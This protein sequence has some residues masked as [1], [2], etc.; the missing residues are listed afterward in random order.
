[1]KLILSSNA[2]G[3]NFAENII[4]EKN[5]AHAPWEFGYA[6]AASRPLRMK[7]STRECR[8]CAE[9]V[10]MGAEMYGGL[11]DRCSF[12]THQTSH[13]FAPTANWAMPNGTSFTFSPSFGLND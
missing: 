1:M 7:A 13:Y 3:W 5:L 9:N 10:Q 2:K 6:L 8:F 4:A 12:G 11:G